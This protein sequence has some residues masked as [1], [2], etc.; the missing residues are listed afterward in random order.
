MKILYP[1]FNSL[2]FVVM[3]F[4]NGLANG[5]P[6]NGYNTGQI[7]DMYPSLFTPAGI[8]FSIWGLIY[9]WLFVW[10]IFQWLSLQN[11]KRFIYI[12]SVSPWFWMS[13]V[14]NA[15]WIVSWHYLFPGISLL[16]M[17]SL[18]IVLIR[19]FLILI[20]SEQV[21]VSGKD[22][23]ISQVFHVYLAWICVATIANT[24]AWLLSLHIENFLL[25]ESEWT[26]VM[27]VTACALAVI[28]LLRYSTK[29]FALVVIWALFGIALRW[30]DANKIF[31][32]TA[33]GLCVIILGVMSGLIKRKAV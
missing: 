15:S 3:V 9:S 32:Y 21:Q 17:I 29:A 24:A 31:F 22:N 4:F 28:M 30:Q 18:L 10:L 33:I 27:M 2:M 8:T 5:L 14:L 20:H 25:S 16:I 7:S 6:L 23:L 13:C 19:I 26:I 11:E 12:K 1:L